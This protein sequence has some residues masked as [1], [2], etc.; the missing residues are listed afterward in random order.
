[1]SI[2][3]SDMA[4]TAEYRRILSKMGYYNYQNSLIYRHINQ[5][6]GWDKHLSNC[7]SFIMR[8]IEKASPEKVTILGSGWL[9]DLP[10]AELMDHSRQIT[11]VDIVH[12]PEV[13]TQVS[14][15]KK[16]KLLEADVT[17][18]LINEVWNK[19][20]NKFLF[21]KNFQRTLIN[22]PEYIPDEDPGLIISLNILTQLEALP[23]DFI[24]KKF[25][26]CEEEI[27]D[28]KFEVQK[29]HIDFLKNYPSVLISD[30]EEIFK[31]TDGTENP[32]KTLLTQLPN[33]GNKEEWVWDFDLM[34]G[35][36][37]NRRSIMKVVAL[38]MNI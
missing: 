17:G 26:T 6:G 32:E 18:G 31:E 25:K 14:E 38:T 11:L 9:L 12:P 24:R 10:L 8:A 30:I 35:D 36:Y 28:F 4:H 33:S 27:T 5:D 19:A 13:I 22:I 34:G 29:K 1:M 15:Y 2:I 37:Y 7:R 20:G 3:F 23:V 21:K 16:V